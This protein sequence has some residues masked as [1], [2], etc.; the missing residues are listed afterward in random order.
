MIELVTDYTLRKIMALLLMSANDKGI[1][2]VTG[3]AHCQRQ[4]A[5]FLIYYDIIYFFQHAETAKGSQTMTCYRGV[6]RIMPT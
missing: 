4:V 3:R 5:F 1:V 6:V 2:A